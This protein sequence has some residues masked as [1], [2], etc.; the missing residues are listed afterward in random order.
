[1]LQRVFSGWRRVMHGS[2][3]REGQALQ[4]MK[5]AWR[6]SAPVDRVGV[7]LHFAAL[8][9]ASSWMSGEVWRVSNARAG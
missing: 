2:R 5:V 7:D 4:K 3:V 8:G 6:S 1:M 9:E